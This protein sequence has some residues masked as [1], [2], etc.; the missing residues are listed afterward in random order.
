MISG[1]QRRGDRFTLVPSQADGAT[2]SYSDEYMHAAL[3]INI[4]NYTSAVVTTAEIV[5]AISWHAGT[6]IGAG[7]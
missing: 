5:G 2:R 7:S 6:K 4:P 1:R 3:E